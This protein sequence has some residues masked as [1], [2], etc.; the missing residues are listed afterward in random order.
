V[1]EVI[2]VLLV[3]DHPA[4]R[5]G[6]RVLLEQAGIPVI[7]EA[8]SGREALAQIPA[9]RPDV[10]V[11]D[12][13]LP[14]TEGTAVA[15]ELK[16]LGLPS[17][18][19]ALSSYSDERYVRAMIDAGAVGY[20]LKDEAPERIVEAVRTAA[21]GTR[22]WTADQ[23]LRGQRWQEE[24]KARWEQLTPREREVLQ[25]L[26]TGKGNQQIA[27]ELKVQGKAVEYHVTNILSKLGVRSRAEA[28]VWVRNSGL[29]LEK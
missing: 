28:I 19:L 11:L 10:I 13:Q 4:L 7:G 29:G 18:V 8:G 9:L 6:L 3:D 25:L 14:D 24:V 12:C 5:V 16:R 17:R 15:M 21:S 26:A 22:L 1:S 23:V 2:R 27:R 20:L